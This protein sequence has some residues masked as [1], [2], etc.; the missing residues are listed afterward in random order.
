MDRESV[1]ILKELT[2]DISSRFGNGE[3]IQCLI[4]EIKWYE[5]C[6]AID[7]C[8]A[9]NAIDHAKTIW[10]NKVR[11]KYR[12]DARL[13]RTDDGFRKLILRLANWMEKELDHLDS[14]V[15]VK[16]HSKMVRIHGTPFGEKCLQFS[17]MHVISHPESHPGVILNILQLIQEF[18]WK[19]SFIPNC[20][21][22]ETL[23]YS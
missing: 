4:N 12:S 18:G 2:E 14:K 20:Q 13:I 17:D 5:Y 10:S 15:V 11:D 19:Y 23:D 7:S 9:R 21:P 8:D 1:S 16:R 22:V 3:S 6:K